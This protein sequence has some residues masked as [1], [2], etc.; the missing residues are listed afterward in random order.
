MRIGW[1]APLL[2]ALALGPAFAE[3]VVPV[4]E[5]APAATIDAD[6]ARAVMR[7]LQ[8]RASRDWPKVE[9]V[10]ANAKGAPPGPAG[11]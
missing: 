2:F 3:S 9:A 7:E 10:V 5:D 4:S 11:T 6:T 8:N 1:T